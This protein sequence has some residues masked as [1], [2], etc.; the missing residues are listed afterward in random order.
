MGVLNISKGDRVF[1]L[2]LIKG[3]SLIIGL[4]F[5]F[6]KVPGKSIFVLAS[7]A[8]FSFALTST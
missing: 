4:T 3:I 1:K 8:S 5:S 2:F 6:T 7:G